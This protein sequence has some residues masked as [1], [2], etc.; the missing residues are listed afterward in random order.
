MDPDLDPD[1][2]KPVSLLPGA[3]QNVFPFR[4]F[5]VPLRLKTSL[6]EV[7]NVTYLHMC[8]S[9]RLVIDLYIPSVLYN[10]CLIVERENLREKAL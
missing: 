6:Q 9:R 5:P 8:A 10:H 1:F 4:F 3:F 2:L 7:R